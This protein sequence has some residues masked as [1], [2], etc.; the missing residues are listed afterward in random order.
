V[1]ETVAESALDGIIAPLF[2]MS[3]GGVPLAMAY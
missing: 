1:I 2:Y 3:V